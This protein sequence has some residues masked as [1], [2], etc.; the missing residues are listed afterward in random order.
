VKKVASEQKNNIVKEPTVFETIDEINADNVMSDETFEYLFTTKDAE[1]QQKE[2]E[3]CRKVARSVG[4]QGA[5]NERLKAWRDAEQRALQSGR[6]SNMTRF[7]GKQDK[8]KELKCGEWVADQKGVRMYTASN[9]R[10]NILLACSIPIYISRIMVNRQDKTARVE[11][12]YKYKENHNW[13][14]TIVKRSTISDNRAII[15]LADF[16]I[17]VSSDTAKYLVKYLAKLMD[18]NDIPIQESTSKLG[19]TM[20]DNDLQF[21]IPKAKS[22]KIFFDAEDNFQNIY[23]SIEIKGDFNQWL[24]LMLELRKEARYEFMI[25]MAAAAASILVE[26]L[27][28]NPFITHL[29]GQTEGGKTVSLMLATSLFANPDPEG[30]Y[31]G[32]FKATRTAIEAKSDMLNNLPIVL[33]DTAQISRSVNDNFSDLI[34]RLCSGAGKERSNVNL[35]MRKTPTWKTSVITS[36]EHPLTNETAQG[37]AVNRVISVEAK[38]EKIF[39]DGHHIVEVIKENYG[40]GL[41]LIGFVKSI[42]TREEKENKDDLT[43]KDLQQK[44][45]DYFKAFTEHRKMEK[46]AQAGALIMLGDELLEMFLFRDGVRLK[47][48]DLMPFLRDDGEISEELRCFRWLIDFTREHEANFYDDLEKSK[49]VR[50]NWGRIDREKKRIYYIPGVLERVV[51]NDSPYSFDRFKKWA[52]RNNVLKRQGDR[53]TF[54]ARM[55]VKETENGELRSEEQLKPKTCYAIRYDDPNVRALLKKAE[56]EVKNQNETEEIIPFDTDDD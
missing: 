15:K 11:L 22:D 39:K 17:P 29:Y 18:L 3:Y 49:V 34:Y 44:L 1:I 30:H 7:F 35:G 9:G 16:N 20:V 41:T 4:N 47:A 40:W 28:C 45:S 37:G 19:W 31:I 50:N 48:S 36:G 46:Q 32:N 42:L 14:S 54:K 13:K 51:N 10:E 12:T 56:P 55:Y 52:K 8:S 23:S 21:L 53:Y 33:D 25:P 26:P 5:F 27:N 43:K 6:K 24:S 38:P 2:I